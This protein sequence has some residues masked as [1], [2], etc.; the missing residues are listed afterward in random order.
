MAEE[1]ESHRMPFLE[2]RMSGKQLWGHGD[3]S[4]SPGQATFWL[5]QFVTHAYFILL[6]VKVTVI[7]NIGKIFVS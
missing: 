5:C 6:H 7:S 1:H 4:S 3:L 2:A